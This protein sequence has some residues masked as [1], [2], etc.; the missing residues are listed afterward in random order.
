MA[1]E[2]VGP[3]S[4][5]SVRDESRSLVTGAL[6]FRW[7]WMLWMTGLAAMSSGELVH[8]W[9]AWTAL[10]VA[11]AWTVWLSLA[12]RT[13][14][15]AVMAI[16]LVICAG[17]ILISGLVVEEGAIVSGRPFFATGYPLSAPLLWGALWGPG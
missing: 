16:D 13:W 4:L 8:D 14:N 2:R 7:V 3:R 11:G 10:A 17:L 5:D 15:R 1:L 12:R 6:L 9:L